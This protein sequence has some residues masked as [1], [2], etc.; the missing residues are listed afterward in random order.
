M[1]K[2]WR[3]V[4]MVTIGVAISVLIP[5]V[6]VAHKAD[7]FT[8]NRAGPIKVGK[9]TLSEAKDWFGEPTKRRRVIVGCQVK[10]LKVKWGNYLKIYFSR[11]KNRKV[12]EVWVRDRTITF[13]GLGE[14]TM[15]T[16]QG[17]R[18]DASRR[19]IKDLYPKARRYRLNGRT[20]FELRPAGPVKGRVRAYVKEG[21]VTAFA[22]PPWEYC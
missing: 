13:D 12:T 18:V 8:A 19:K 14:L 3:C 9:T 16:R 6:S 10:L 4:G 5:G 21:R 17:L 2:T 20:W 7:L 1:R 11:G 15:H 22:N